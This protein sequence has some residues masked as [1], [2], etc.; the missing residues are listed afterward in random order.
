LQAIV[1][2]SLGYSMV[3]NRSARS[4]LVDKSVAAVRVHLSPAV[5]LM[6]GANLRTKP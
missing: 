1:G 3:L 2:L 5:T 4:F 6:W